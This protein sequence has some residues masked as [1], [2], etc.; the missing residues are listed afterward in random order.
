M[1]FAEVKSCIPFTPASVVWMRAEMS[2][3]LISIQK[4][5]LSRDINPEMKI[6]LFFNP[7]IYYIINQN[8]IIDSMVVGARRVNLA[9]GKFR[10]DS[11]SRR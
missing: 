9:E 5:K 2:L 3:K 8:S 6:S 4:N 7:F 11:I 10:E 1:T